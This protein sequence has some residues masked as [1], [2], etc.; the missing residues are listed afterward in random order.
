LADGYF[1]TPFTPDSRR[2]A[3]WQALVRNYFQAKV[4][5]SNTVLE[6]GAG[7]GHFIDNIKAARHLKPGIEFH[8]GAVSDLNFVVDNSVDF[9]LASH[10]F[11]HVPQE[12][13]ASVLKQL[14]AKLRPGGT[15]DLLQ[16]N[17][18]FA[19][20]E[21]FDDYTHTTFYSDISIVGKQML[22]QARPSSGQ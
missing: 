15:L 16:P 12:A 3:L 20:R 6:P 17:Y 18:R 11:E 22:V 10:L 5:Q 7:F 2:E 19:F 21:Y 1:E 4:A 9:V 13:F 8:G 14:R